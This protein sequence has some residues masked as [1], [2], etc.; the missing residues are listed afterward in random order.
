MFLQGK[1]TVAG[2]LYD[3]YVVSKEGVIKEMKNERLIL[4]VK[5]F[6][7]KLCLFQCYEWL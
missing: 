5:D 6:K 4:L 3:T 7:M 2:L 1:G